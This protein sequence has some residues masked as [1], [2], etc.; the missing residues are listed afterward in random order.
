MIVSLDMETYSEAGY[1]F[2]D[3]RWRAPENSSK[4]GLP[5]VGAAVYAEHPTAEILIACYAFD[6][7]PVHTWVQGMPPPEDLLAHVRA[8]GIVQAYNSMFEWL[9]WDRVATVKYGWP[10]LFLANTRDTQAR[11]CAYGLPWKLAKAAEALG[12]PEQKS[13]E[14]TSLIKRFTTPRSPTKNDPSLRNHMGDD[15]PR[16]LAFYQYCAQDVRTERGVGDAVP[17][18]SDEELEVWK[19]DQ[20]INERGVAIDAEA[21]E[22]CLAL[23]AGVTERLTAELAYITNGK[24]TSA[25]Q[26]ERMQE[27][28][29]LYGIDIPDMT[30]PTILATL[31]DPFHPVHEHPW[32]RRVLEI[33]RDLASASVKKLHAIKRHLCSDGRVRGLF[34]Y[35]GAERTGRWAGRGAQPQNLPRGDTK[36]VKCVRCNEWAGAHTQRCWICKG[37]MEPGKWGHGAALGALR[38]FRGRSVDAAENQ[39]GGVLK[40]IAGC[41]RSMFVAGPGRTFICSDYRAIEAVVL[42]QLAGEEWRLEVFRTH[43]KI[44]EQSAS[45]I[46]GIPFE[47][48]QAYRERTGE[49][50]PTRQT[51]GKPAELASGYGGGW[52]AWAHFGADEHL[53]EEEMKANVKLWRAASPHIAGCW[54]RRITGIWKG[55]ENAAMSAIENRGQAY[56]YRGITYHSDG[57]VLRCT[58]PSGRALTY[59]QPSVEPCIMPWGDP[60]KRIKFYGWNSNPKYGALGWRQLDTYGGRLTENVV[61]AVARD[62]LAHGMRNA[63]RAGYRIVMHIHDEIVCEQTPGE[64]SV[65]DLEERM[66]DLPPWAQGWPVI[67]QGGWAGREYRK[68]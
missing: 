60:G 59:H 33:R 35:S 44:Y 38:S 10:K 21:L 20:E 67:A 29:A 31:E 1:V 24:I 6:D 28:L 49:H 9:M 58:L 27:M 18:L 17:W 34:V 2:H 55:L 46:T 41:L 23:V 63:A 62:L 12:T 37:A 26:T 13:S 54:K 43:G 39:W 48:Y 47:E 51:I 11:S 7:G 40:A 52:R 15:H 42:A 45:K 8:G 14:G 68:E 16:A 36:V 19:L 65:E 64:G 56:A 32:A 5:A 66:G 30:A 4:S 22:N 25:G 50:H 61:Q 53:T 3:G 57:R